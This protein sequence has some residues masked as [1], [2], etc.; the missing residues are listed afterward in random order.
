MKQPPIK[1]FVKTLVQHILQKILLL[2]WE[3]GH[4]SISQQVRNYVMDGL[5]PVPA[6]TTQNGFSS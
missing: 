6:H 1:N 5:R 4:V 2:W 3:E